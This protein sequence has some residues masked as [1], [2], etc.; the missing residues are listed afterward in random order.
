MS[1]DTDGDSINDDITSKLS[2]EILL[3]LLNE[4]AIPPY[5]IRRTTV[6]PFD[7]DRRENDAEHSF[8]LGI[9]ALCAAPLLDE[10]LDSGLVAQYALV[11]DLVEIYAGDTPVY[12]D[13][14]AKRTKQ[15]RERQAREEINAQFRGVCP[16]ILR[17]IDEYNKL[18]TPEARFVYA[19]DKII[20]HAM[21][22]LG[23]FHPVKPG[24]GE[25]KQTERTAS[26][27]IEQSCPALVPIF[28]ELCRRYT[29][30]PQLFSTPPDPAD[31]ALALI[32]QDSLEGGH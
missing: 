18:T 10:P 17:R 11:H 23:D 26:R 7:H 19:L 8:S 16:D 15:S 4:L 24:W 25:Y 22:I 30:M 5:R 32:K 20:P 2:A 13:P 12:R 9:V 21:V 31:V 29:L 28:D 6:V 3:T 14:A 1:S 27:K